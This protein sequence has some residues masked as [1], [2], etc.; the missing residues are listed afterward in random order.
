MTS[1]RS[2]SAT[3]TAR[4]PSSSA[5]AASTST[6]SKRSH[7]AT[8]LAGHHRTSFGL[9][10]IPDT[11]TIAS[12][13]A[14]VPAAPSGH[15]YHAKLGPKRKSKIGISAMHPSTSGGRSKGGSGN[16]G[17]SKKEKSKSQAS[18][19]NLVGEMNNHPDL[20]SRSHSGSATLEVGMGGGNNGRVQ[21][22]KSRE[23]TTSRNR[24]ASVD[25]DDADAGWVSAASSKAGTPEN[26]NS[27]GTSP[28]SFRPLE[29][30]KQS[31]RRKAHDEQAEEGQIRTSPYASCVGSLRGATPKQESALR[32]GAPSGILQQQMQLESPTKIRGDNEAIT[33]TQEKEAP[34]AVSTSVGAQE[35]QQGQSQQ[36]QQPAARTSPL[37]VP[38]SSPKRLPPLDP[39][40]QSEHS[41][42][43]TQA[44]P[45]QI[46]QAPS[47][48]KDR[49]LAPRKASTS[50]IRSITSMSGCLPLSPSLRRHSGALQP[51]LDTQV[52]G[53]GTI[54]EQGRSLR[55]SPEQ[56][57]SSSDTFPPAKGRE[58]ASAALGHQRHSS[59][60]QNRIGT[61]TS[62][63][64]QDLA[65]R[66]RTVSGT[67]L[68]SLDHHGATGK[69]ALNR[70]A[71]TATTPLSAP[72]PEPGHAGSSSGGGGGGMTNTLKRASGYF[73]SIGRL[74][75]LAGF[76]SANAGSTGNTPS[77]P[78]L[79]ERKRL[80]PRLPI[81]GSAAQQVLPSTSPS[82]KS[83]GF[84]SLRKGQGSQ[85]QVHRQ[86]LI[87]K[88]IEPSDGYIP[89][90]KAA[91]TPSS[92]E[93]GQTEVPKASHQRSTTAGSRARQKMMTQRDYPDSD[94][95]LMNNRPGTKASD[96]TMPGGYRSS[97]SDEELATSASQVNLRSGIK[98][99]HASAST[100]NRLAPGV[101]R[102]ITALV[103][104]AERIDKDHETAMRF[105][106][107][108]QA[109]MARVLDKK[110]ARE[111]EERKADA[112]T[113]RER[114]KDKG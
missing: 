1:S 13:A 91:A 3:T 24:E 62:A 39:A 70:S 63:E 97:A 38:A 36:H 110:A 66:L 48:A 11:N 107:S 32:L 34:L 67:D 27:P 17:L 15:E 96:P 89:F 68:K 12:S 14:A 19:A 76:T 54:V 57:R 5:S 85:Q 21:R 102:W 45:S 65:K 30:G 78:S 56:I 92:R 83:V 98:S 114:E 52:E 69:S 49:P 99:V 4:H 20:Q 31:R 90:P 60:T 112:A 44:L 81:L 75:S 47:A 16:T 86:P 43:N 53:F 40:R 95:E 58:A 74:A 51:R 41:I 64:A 7:S 100:Q 73:G 113:K 46:P 6:S 111:E 84:A 22:S 33:P 105:N 9:T 80:S 42:L 88:F 50:T 10:A 79:S 18:L 71:S 29:F 77:T 109:S 104:E 8:N 23:A 87:S 94:T 103:K 25:P 82:Q 108:V 101:Q 61:L 93:D 59:A 37:G 28:H 72:S 106:N 55:I 35:Q 26:G 2:S